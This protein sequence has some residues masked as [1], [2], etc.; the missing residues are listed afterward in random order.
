MA[1]NGEC[2]SLG[3]GCTQE[4]EEPFVTALSIHTHAPGDAPQDSVTWHNPFLHDSLSKELPDNVWGHGVTQQHKM[5][6][7]TFALAQG[8]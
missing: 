3:R 1:W 4:G 2:G 5:L 8:G 6:L 7:H